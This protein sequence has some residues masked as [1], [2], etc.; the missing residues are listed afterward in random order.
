MA[1]SEYPRQTS[2]AQDY[3]FAK[4]PEGYSF[5]EAGDG[6]PAIMAQPQ[7]FYTT[8]SNYNG[9]NVTIV[10]QEHGL[11]M[12]SNRFV[13]PR[14]KETRCRDL[15]SQGIAAIVYGVLSVGLGIGWL[16]VGKKGMVLQWGLSVGTMSAGIWGGVFAVVGGALALFGAEKVG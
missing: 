6:R 7:V 13:Y 14:P 5:S 1:N 2:V 11:A 9:P 15:R 10:Q 8:N 12:N 3:A 4:H 16:V